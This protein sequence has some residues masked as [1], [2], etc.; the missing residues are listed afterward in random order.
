MAF[1]LSL[2]PNARLRMTVQN[3]MTLDKDGSVYNDTLYQ[4]YLAMH[5]KALTKQEG[6]LK[7]LTFVDA[8]LALVLFGKNVKIPGTDVGLQDIPATVQVLTALSSFA[9]L[10]VSLSF[11]NAQCYLAIIEQFNIRKARSQHLDPDFITAADT[12]TELYLKAFRSQLNFHGIDFFEPGRGY[13]WF[14]S[15]MIGLLMAAM[16]CVLILH[17]SVASAGI[18]RSFSFHWIPGLFCTAVALINVVAILAN[19]LVGFTFT[20]DEVISS[21][22]R[23]GQSDR[24]T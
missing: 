11:L 1:K 10:M 7:S 4:K 9:F 12:F 20:V 22:P 19:V 18:W 21:E 24:A 2:S 17:V 15:S 16:A 8:A 14:F 13:R 6:L 5:A 23:T 3:E